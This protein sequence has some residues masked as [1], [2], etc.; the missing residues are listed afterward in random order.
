MDSQIVN[1]IIQAGQTLP[2]FQTAEGFYVIACSGVV[3]IRPRDGV[4]NTYYTGTGEQA[5]N[6]VS[7]DL[8]EV[9]NATANAI[10]LS[11]WVGKGSYIDHRFIQ[12]SGLF[13]NIAY[14]TYPVASAATNLVVTDRSG[15]QILDVNG[16]AWLALNRVAIYITNFDTVNSIALRDTALAVGSVFSC[17]PN[18]SA[19]LTM[20]GTYRINL[21]GTA[22]NCIVSEVYNSIA[23][24]LT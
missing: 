18:T 1:T 14:P 7:F 23:P 17:L 3:Q 10:T 19:V 8:L 16:K 12:V 2:I 20:D 24:T 6:G 4:F 22:L 21:G 13:N 9:M 5:V 15:T 11:I